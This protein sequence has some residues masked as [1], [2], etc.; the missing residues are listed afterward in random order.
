MNLE[1]HL[2]RF[3]QKQKYNSGQSVKVFYLVN[4]NN[5]NKILYTEFQTLLQGLL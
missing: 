1:N 3:S 2:K 5:N 4:N